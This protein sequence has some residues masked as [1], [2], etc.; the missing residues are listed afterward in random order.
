MAPRVLVF[1]HASFCP[2]GTL[3]DGLEEDGIAPTIVELDQGHEIPALDL[4]DIL[5]VLGGPME[6]WE[7]KQHPWLVPEKQAIRKW[8]EEFDKPLLGICL[9][10]QVLAD[11]LGGGVGPALQSEVGVTDVKLASAGRESPAFAGFGAGKRAVSWHGSEVK[12]LPSRAK[13]LASTDDCPIAA[14]SVGSAAFGLQYHVEATT[15]LVREWAETPSG[16]TQVA[17]LRG[18]DGAR[19]V[20]NEVSA[21]MPEL[22]ANAR[23]FY[24]NFMDAARKR[25]R[26]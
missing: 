11:A 13:L 12:K 24:D 14:F 3:G 20:E 17:S 10:H 8:V 25:L 15:A 22:R 16:A 19:H 4:F 7:E 23:R 1:Q 6:T 21:V 9:G 2:L 5:I 26:T 18:P